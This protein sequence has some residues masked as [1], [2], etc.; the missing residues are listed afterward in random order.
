[1]LFGSPPKFAWLCIGNC[2]RDELL[3]LIERHEA[4]ILAFETSLESVLVL[5]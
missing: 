4:D 3:A 5:S 1:L 2:T